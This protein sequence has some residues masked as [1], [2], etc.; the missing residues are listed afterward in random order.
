[1]N[2]FDPNA[3]GTWF[4]LGTF[5]A[6][7]LDAAFPLIPQELF[8][9]AIPALTG[10]GIIN[11]PLAAAVTVIGHVLGE[12]WL[13]WVV[14]TRHGWLNKRRWGR[15]LLQSADS[16]AGSLGSAGS[17]SVLVGLRF[18]SGGRT[19][20]CVGAGLSKLRWSLVWWSSC[21]GSTL[22]VLYM[23]TL[24]GILHSLLGLPAWS[25]AIL[26]MIIGS[27]LGVVPLVWTHK[28]RRRL[29]GD[30]SATSLPLEQSREEQ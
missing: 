8:A 22:W 4:Y 5:L 7:V 17:F 11:G 29:R 2:L 15:R 10:Q 20:A 13:T 12:V 3:W 30:V 27:V 28:R 26:G 9:L 18:I 19:V 23:I 21:V 24:G 6:Q 14:R 1:M 16:A 25:S